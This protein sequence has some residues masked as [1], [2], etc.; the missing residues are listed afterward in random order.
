VMVLMSL[1]LLS[2]T[3]E[4]FPVGASGGAD[5]AQEIVNLLVE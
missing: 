2:T 1:I 3:N 5:F 4:S